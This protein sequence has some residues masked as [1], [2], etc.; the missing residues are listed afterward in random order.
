MSPELIAAATIITIVAG[1]FTIAEF[2]WK[3]IRRF[4]LRRSEQTASQASSTG[5][6]ASGT[7]VAGDMRTTADRSGVAVAAR[8]QAPTI[9]A[10]AGAN[11]NFYQGEFQRSQDPEAS[12]AYA[13]GVRFQEEERHREAIRAFER[14]FAA[15]RDPRNRANLHL[16]IGISLLRLSRT[17]EAEGHFREASDALQ[18][19]TRV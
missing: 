5:V 14:A 6:G 19:D 10:Q 13:E 17:T 8:Q 4:V 12:D 15:A 1:T 9:I 7:A 11:V 18:S 3:P 2:T 16:L